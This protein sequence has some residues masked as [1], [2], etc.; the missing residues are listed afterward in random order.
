M[1]LTINGPGTQVFSGSNTYTGTTTISAGVLQ[2]G[3]G[4]AGQNGSVASIVDN[5]RLVFNNG[6][7]QTYSGNISGTGTLT[8]NGSASLFLAGANSYSGSTSVNAG[9]LQ[10]NASGAIAGS[11]RNIAV[12]AA[13][14]AALGYVPAVSIQND[15]LGRIVA[16]SSGA[17]A[18]TANTSENF[19][20]SSGG[21][22]NN[23]TSLSLGG[24]APQLIRAP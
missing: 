23:F 4:A 22:G 16:S 9:L 8:K 19:D 13:A 1:T 21:P 6:D 15:L 17:L 3:T 2:L 5:A 20:F 18:L 24:A 12:N 10:Y 7:A 11:G 14:A